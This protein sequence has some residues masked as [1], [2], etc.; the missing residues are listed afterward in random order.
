MQPNERRRKCQ[1]AI[2]V[3]SLNLQDPP[4]ASPFALTAE[5]Y[6]LYTRCAHCLVRDELPEQPLAEKNQ[7]R[8]AHPGRPQ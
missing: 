3:A 1:R 6:G 2:R 7:R 5:W 8:D 4:L